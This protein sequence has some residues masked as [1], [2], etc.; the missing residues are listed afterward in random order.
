MLINSSP[1]HLTTTPLAAQGQYLKHYLIML[2]YHS[3]TNNIKH[4]KRSVSK[5]HEKAKHFKIKAYR[6]YSNKRRIWDK[7]VNK[8]RPRISAAPPMRRLFEE[9]RITRKNTIN[10]SRTTK[11]F[12]LTADIFDLVIMKL[13]GFFSPREF[14]S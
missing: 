11:K 12:A 7:K 2:Y 8:R 1:N 10:C 5:L 13:S 4:C 9:F 14:L 3:A 6:I